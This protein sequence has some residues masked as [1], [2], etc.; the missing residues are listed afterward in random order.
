MVQ[1]ESFITTF[2][3]QVRAKTENFL[4]KKNYPQALLS[5]TKQL[6]KL[7]YATEWTMILNEFN[8]KLQNSIYM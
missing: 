5:N 1:G 6:W 7:D 8:L 3:F 4:N 2:F